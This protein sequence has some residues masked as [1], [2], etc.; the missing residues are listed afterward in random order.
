VGLL[1]VDVL[2]LLV[3]GAELGFVCDLVLAGAFEFGLVA[4]AFKD[5]SLLSNGPTR[6]S[7][8]S[9]IVSRQIVTWPALDRPWTHQAWTGQRRQGCGYLAAQVAPWGLAR[10]LLERFAT[11]IGSYRGGVWFLLGKAW[12]IVAR[13]NGTCG[14]G[15]K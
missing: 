10:W 13:S 8:L 7:A 11:P 14:L 3:M 4:V 6:L 1:T 2:R 9:R 12:P 5:F 15:W